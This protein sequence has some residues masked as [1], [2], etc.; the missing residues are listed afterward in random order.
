MISLFRA[1]GFRCLDNVELRLDPCFNLISGANASGKTSI[2]EALAYL[3]RGRSFRGAHPESLTQHGKKQFI[4]YGEIEDTDKNISMGVK[5]GLGGLE[6]RI[7]GES[8]KGISTLI[9]TLPLQ[10]IDP[11]IHNLVSGGPERR[12]QYIDWVTFHVEHGYLKLWRKY[13]RSLK[14]RNAALKSKSKRSLIQS[15][16][17]EFVELASNIDEARKKALEKVLL[18]FESLG[19]KI[20]N[21]E[22]SFEY[23]EGWSSKKDLKIALDD[24]YE[25]DIF[26]GATQN[27]PHRADLKIDLTK[28]QARKLV[29]RGQQ[30]LLASA[31]V[32]AATETVQNSL[33]KPL[34]LLLDDPAAELDSESVYRL[35]ESVSSLGC[36]VVATSINPQNVKF[37]KNPK[38]FHVEQGYISLC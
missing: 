38:M 37:S 30:K 33:N 14:Q 28:K 6:T 22:F 25:R 18:N 5:N 34:L 26:L 24:G 36:Q 31:M 17:K 10:V 3:G 23:Q 11:E 8:A 2:L 21:L 7:N 29:S 32:L 16:D 13:K 15:W 19:R 1:T 27:G 12:R 9:E 20:I 4:L 35:M